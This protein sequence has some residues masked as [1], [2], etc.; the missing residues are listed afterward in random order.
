[1]ASEAEGIFGNPPSGAVPVR[2]NG[3]FPNPPSMFPLRNTDVCANSGCSR[4]AASSLLPAPAFRSYC[5]GLNPPFHLSAFKSGPPLPGF[6]RREG[7]DRTNGQFNITSTYERHVQNCLEFRN[8][9]WGKIFEDS[10]GKSPFY[11]TWYMGQL[12]T[13]LLLAVEQQLTTMAAIHNTF[14][15]GG[16]TGIMEAHNV[17]GRDWWVPGYGG[18]NEYKA[19]VGGDYREAVKQ[20]ADILSWLLCKWRRGIL[21]W[22]IIHGPRHALSRVSCVILAVLLRIWFLRAEWEVHMG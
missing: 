2:Y 15:L 9:V 18:P 8:Q 20:S 3:S 16:V 13:S 4:E 11:V 14:E 22:Q 5:S 17:G 7:Q 19:W 1:M 10:A 21:L 12:H 6:V